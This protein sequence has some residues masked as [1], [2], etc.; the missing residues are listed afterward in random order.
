MAEGIPAVTLGA[1]GTITAAHTT[2]ES[3]RNDG[4]PDGI[5]R[6]AL[7]LMVLDALPASG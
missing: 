2:D 6:A 4:G 1:G 5:A 3:Y 7:T